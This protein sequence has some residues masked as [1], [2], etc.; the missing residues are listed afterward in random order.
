MKLI[1]SILLLLVTVVL[2]S[3][4][5]TEPPAP[6][7]YEANPNFSWGFADFYGNYYQNY[8]IENNVVTLNL[9]TQKLF[10]N[11]KNQLDGAGQYLIIEDIF[12]TP[13]DTLLPAGNYKVAE[14]GKSFT[15]FGGKKFE[16]NRETIPSGA[17]IYYIETDPTK[18]KI[19]YVTDGSMNI[20]IESDT[21]YNITCDFT[22]DEKT[23]FKGNFKQVLYH[24]ERTATTP[25]SSARQ[26]MQL[27]N[28]ID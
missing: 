27:K 21:I 12:S 3:C 2:F 18:S 8:G 23:A 20:S 15:F 26:K 4:K 9:F 24:I 11:E 14:T 1:K 6:Y 19:A 28:I 7:S 22:L 5:P 16:D 25:P 17:F 13:N 10:I